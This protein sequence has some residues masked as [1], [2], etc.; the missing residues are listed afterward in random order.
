MGHLREQL[1]SNCP[2]SGEYRSHTQA[3][4]RRGGRRLNLALVSLGGV[5]LA[6]SVGQAASFLFDA[7]LPTGPFF[8]DLREDLIPANEGAF[9]GGDTGTFTDAGLTNSL[10]EDDLR[11]GGGFDV[12]TGGYPSPL[13]GAESFSMT[14]L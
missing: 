7:S 13:F 12:P 5:F 3:R 6:V 14:A 1:Y 2:K 4:R 10:P 8:G 11:S 9:E